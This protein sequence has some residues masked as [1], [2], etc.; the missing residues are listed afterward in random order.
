M[1]TETTGLIKKDDRYV[2]EKCGGQNFTITMHQDAK[3]YYIN[4]YTCNN[5]GA[6][7]SMKRYRSEANKKLFGR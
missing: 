2:C 6:G 1:E 7:V 4:N 3:D 5:C